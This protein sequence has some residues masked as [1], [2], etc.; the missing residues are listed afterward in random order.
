MVLPDGNPWGAGLIMFDRR[1][2]RAHSRALKRLPQHTRNELAR[3]NQKSVEEFERSAKALVPVLTGETQLSIEAGTYETDGG[4]V[5][6]MTAGDG[7][8]NAPARI[9][10]FVN[11]QPFF[12]PT[13]RLFRKRWYGRARRAVTKTAKIA[14]IES[15]Q[16]G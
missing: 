7:T 8:D 6:T 1:A 12:Y 4:F 9:V 10:E 2:V 14:A 5:L 15:R 16:G 3:V 11:D 13:L